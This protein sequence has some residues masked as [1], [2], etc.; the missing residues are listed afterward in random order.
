MAVIRNLVVKIGA[1]TSGLSK[2]LKAAQTNLKKVSTSLTS[3]GTSMTMGITVP[4]IALGTA[5]VSIS[6]SFEQSMANAASVSGATADELERMTEL[7]REMGSSTV[8]SASE[9][10]DAM[11]YLASAGYDVEQMAASLEPILNLAAATQSELAFTTDTVVATLNQFG[12]EASESERVTNVF[13]SVIGN[14]QATLEKLAYSMRYVG[15]VANS[16][17]YSIEE[18]TAALGLLY[19]SGY[20][21]EQAGTILRSA[22]TGLLSP[23]ST[24]TSCLEEMGLTYD[25]VNPSVLTLTEIIKNL[26]D[27][28]IT[29]AQAV[30]LFGTEAGPG[31]MALIEQGSEALEE[32]TAAITG[33]DSASEMA[34]TQLD[35]LTGAIKLLKSQLEEL[36]LQ[37]GDILL[38]IITSIVSDYIYP[39]IQSLSNLGEEVLTNVVKFAALAAAIG[40]ILLILGKVTGVMSTVLGIVGKLSVKSVI[41]Y[42][43]ILIVAIAVA[44]AFSENEEFRE[45]LKSLY[46]IIVSLLSSALNPLEDI[47][48]ALVPILSKV[49]TVMSEFIVKAVNIITDIV[50]WLE[51]VELLDFALFLLGATLAIL[52]TIKMVSFISSIYNA[53]I[54]MGAFILSVGTTAVQAIGKFVVTLLLNACLAL[55]SFKLALASVTIG[56]AAMAAAIGLAFYVFTNWDTLNG[57]QKV[58]AVIGVLTVAL[59]GAAIAFGMFHSAWSLGLAVAG[60]VAGI[61]AV[62]ASVESAKASIPDSSNID[63]ASM[64]NGVVSGIDGYASGGTPANSSLFY[65]NEFG[66]PELVANFGGGTGVANNEM[67]VSAIESAAY[68]GMSRAI[69]EMPQGDSEKV[70]ILEING[71]EFARATFS[72]IVSEGKRRGEW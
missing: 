60:I 58:I 11:Y 52:A 26:E 6:A 5:I 56:L 57:I 40:P 43:V 24:M 2:G 29:T 70:T 14:S 15:P 45:S 54:A 50:L 22:L 63:T 46:T 1:D 23:T 19:N 10:A 18:T 53:I 8:Y 47:F 17:G 7:A 33:T 39:F 66:N 67:I 62:V 72:D 51:K 49:I 4:L 55:G 64:A 71:R 31:M 12:L 16:L 20:Q 37:L 65:A 13:A 69:N 35:T 32:M 59:L 34:E 21:G 68:S 9:A 28:G 27:A 61:V 44:K 38:P 3:I 30:E 48:T 42:G 36:C 41:L 25:D